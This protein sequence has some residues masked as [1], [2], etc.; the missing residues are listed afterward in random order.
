MN[1][2]EKA[3]D[4]IH[5]SQQLKDDTMRFIRKQTA[6]KPKKRTGFI[7]SAAAACCA[8]VFIGVIGIY[9]AFFQKISYV[10]IDVNPSIEISLNRLNR[11]VSAVAMNEDGEKIISNHNLNGMEY[12][13]AVKTVLNAE[14]T[15]G[16]LK[17]EP[18][19]SV[20]VYSDDDATAQTLYETLS[21]TIADEVTAKYGEDAAEVIQVDSDTVSQA[22][23]CGMTAGRYCEYIKIKEYDD[24]VTPEECNNSSMRQLRKR[25]QQCQSEGQGENGSENASQSGE[26]N[27]WGQQEQ[28][29]NSQSTSASSQSS[30]GKQYGKENG[31]Q[32]NGNGKQNGKNNQE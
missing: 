27:K 18:L 17:D 19:V 2:F 11:V 28:G 16:Y 9:G 12:E 26:G 1:R 30:G 24:S 29:Q 6:E 4:E 25:A 15:Q 23:E 31:G 22:H 32:G 7:F 3:F 10:S 20:A 13:E 14:K 5:A 21:G 8:V